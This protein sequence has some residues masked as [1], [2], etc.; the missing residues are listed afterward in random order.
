MAGTARMRKRTASSSCRRGVKHS[1]Y[2]K[3]GRVRN[4]R[5]SG[6]L[7]ANISDPDR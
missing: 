3:T 2:S 1:D 6:K 4:A 5:P 7:L